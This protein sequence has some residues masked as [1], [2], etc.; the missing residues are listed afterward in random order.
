MR[1]QLTLAALCAAAVATPLASQTVIHTQKATIEL[2]GLKRWTKQMID[3]SLSKYAPG[4]SLTGHAC[5]AILR[6]K[7]RFADAAVNV[8]TNLPEYQFKNYV[9]ITVVE[10]SDSAKIVYRPAFRDS[11]PTRANWAAVVDA[12]KNHSGMTQLALQTPSF[13][14]KRLSSE[15]STKFAAITPLHALI[16]ERT[17]ATD[18]DLAIRTLESDGNTF[19]RVA[20]AII[21]SSFADHDAAWWALIDAQRDPS[22]MVAGTALQVARTMARSKARTVDWAPLGPQVRH[23]LNGTNLFSF[24]GTLSVLAATNVSPSLATTLLSGGGGIVSAKLRSG[25]VLAKREIAAFLSRLSGLPASSDVATFE[26][27]VEGL[28]GSP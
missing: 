17:T 26:R 9:A 12:F 20:A 22:G 1:T 25:D 19:N 6:G 14:A 16:L 28:N 23:I 7:L 8:I 5:A 2:I 18:F 4:D 27:W 21:L 24:S 10:P 15:D 3:D 11:L 13:Y